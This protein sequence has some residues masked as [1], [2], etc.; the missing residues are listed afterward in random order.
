MADSVSRVRSGGNFPVVRCRARIRRAPP[1]RPLSQCLGGRFEP[2][3]SDFKGS[4]IQVPKG[5]EYVPGLKEA[6]TAK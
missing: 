2:V 4:S 6:S 3:G 1:R 5:V